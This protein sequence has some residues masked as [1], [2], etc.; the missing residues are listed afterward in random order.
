MDLNVYPELKEVKIYKYHG[1]YEE[2]IQI[3]IKLIDETDEDDIAHYYLLLEYSGCLIDNI[4][5]RIS[6]GVFEEE[7]EDLE[8]AWN[9]LEE[10]KIKFN[11]IFLDNQA[12]LKI[13]K[14][15]GDI[16]CL[17]NK[18]NDKWKHIRKL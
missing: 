9:Y 15:Q 5:M 2:A 8:I 16:E 18:F 13:Y 11:E 6:D 17:D 4:Y 10:C 7:N 1:N 3:L 14:Y 12:L